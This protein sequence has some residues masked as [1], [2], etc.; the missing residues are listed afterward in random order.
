[1][2]TRATAPKNRFT[3]TMHGGAAAGSR[4]SD[5]I[6]IWKRTSEGKALRDRWLSGETVVF[7]L[8]CSLT[9]MMMKGYAGGL[10]VS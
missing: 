5:R 8:L 1:M 10:V 2:Q 7:C 3:E 9:L 4:E 6:S